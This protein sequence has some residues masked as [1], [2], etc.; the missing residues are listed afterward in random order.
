M[1]ETV[2][3]IS[4]SI[5]ALKAAPGVAVA[6]EP[7]RNELATLGLG[8]ELRGRIVVMTMRCAKAFKLREIDDV[9]RMILEAFNERFPE[10]SWRID[11]FRRKSRQSRSQSASTATAP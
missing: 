4:L 11:K 9:K 2:Y 7:L 6:L 5:D 3:E 10:W 1:N 8:F